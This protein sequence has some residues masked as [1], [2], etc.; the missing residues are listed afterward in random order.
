MTAHQTAGFYL[1]QEER[2]NI[3]SHAIGL[4]CSVVAL[5]LLINRGIAYGSVWHL[6]S[7][8]IYGLSLIILFAASTLYHGASRPVLR[9]WLRIIDHAAIYVLIAG[10]YTPLAL[11]TLGD[12]TGWIIFYI[13]WGLALIGI[14]LKL[15]FTGKF[16][17][18]STLMY[19]C[20][21]WVI[22]FVL[23]PLIETL[24][25]AGLFWLVFGGLAYTLGAI[26]YSIKKMPFNHATFHMFVLLGGSCHFL[27]IYF[28]V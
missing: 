1:P 28:Y 5:V 18:T 9:R 24:P 16:N 7:F 12:T 2:I 3:I 6:V 8:T 26:L 17:K 20:M 19:V 21:G 13:V 4:F 10:T 11:V 23:K 27:A 14:I 15:F 25:P 22:V